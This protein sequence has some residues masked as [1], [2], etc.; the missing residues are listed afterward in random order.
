MIAYIIFIF[1]S[2]GEPI[3]SAE[4]SVSFSFNQCASCLRKK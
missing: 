1:F 3:D 4:S 2:D